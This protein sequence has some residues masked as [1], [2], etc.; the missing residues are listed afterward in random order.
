MHNST[1]GLD[2]S[3]DDFI[4][5]LEVDYNNLWLFSVGEGLSDTDI[6]IGFQS[7]AYSQ[8]SCFEYESLGT[9]TR[10]EAY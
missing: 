2:R 4:V 3:L 8:A 10:V 1:V 5:I 7:L 9:Y 6:M